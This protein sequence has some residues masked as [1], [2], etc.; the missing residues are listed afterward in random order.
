MK[1]LINIAIILTGAALASISCQR[2][3]I[4]GEDSVA[5]GYMKLDFTVN[6][7]VYTDVDTRAVDPD[8]GGVQN[9]TL[10][11]FDENGLFVS[12]SRA[13]LVQGAADEEVGVSLSGKFSV[14][15]PGNTHFVHL[16]GNQN[17]T[18]FEE[19]NYEDMS[20]VEVMT[21]LQASAGRMIYW[22]REEVGNLVSGYTVNL[23]R[24]QAKVTVSIAESATFI[25]DGWVVT[26]TN[27]FGTVAPFSRDH[28][29]FTA[30][31]VTDPFVT[32]PEDN[33]KITGYYD[34]RDVADE[35]FFE[36]ENAEEDPVEFI[37]RGRNDAGSNNLYYRIS[38]ID[39]DGNFLPL[40]RNHNYIVNIVGPL[41]YGSATF[42]EALDSPATNNVWVSISENIPQVYDGDY[43]LSVD[44]TYVVVGEEDFTD[45]NTI[46]LGYTIKA[47]AAGASVD[48]N[49]VQVRWLDGNNVAERGF[50]P[51]T[52]SL[53]AD[54]HGSVTVTLLPMEDLQ[55]REGT[56]LV[57]YGR[58]SRKI[59]VV[60]V[61]KQSFVPSWITTNIYGGSAGENVTMMFTI[62]ETCPA[63]LFPL[64]VLVSVNDLDVRN[65]SGMVLPI[66]RDGDPGYGED[67]GIGYKY[68]HT[69]TGHGIQ[70]LY[71]ETSLSNEVFT[72]IEVTL[73]AD[74]F[75]LLKKTA[76]IQPEIDRYILIHNLRTYSATVPADEVIY[77]YLVPQ[78][79]GAVVKFPTHLGE[80]IIWNSDHTVA[81]WDAVTPGENDEFLI[82]SK[83]LDQDMAAE[84]QDF[85]FYPVDENVWASGGRVYGFKRNNTPDAGQG[86]TYRMIT[87]ASVCDEVVRIASNPF[88]QPSVTGSGT[89]SGG[90]YR[91]A[92]FDLMPF[93]PFRF[94]ATL[95]NVG[96]EQVYLSYEPGQPVDLAFDVTSFASYTGLAQSRTIISGGEQVSVD[97]FGQTFRIYIDAPMLEIDDAR[98]TLPSNKFYEE[99]DGRFVYVVDA[100]RDSERAYFPASTAS[101]ADG[102]TQDYLG[103]TGI[104]VN[105]TGER[106]LLPFRNKGIVSEGKIVLSSEKDLVVY[107]DQSFDLRNSSIAGTAT[108][109]PD[110]TNQTAV[111]AGAFLPF[112]V[113]PT[114]NRIGAITVGADGRYDLRLRSEYI[115]DWDTDDVSI[116]YVD[117]DGNIYEKHYDSIKELFDA[118]DIKLTPVAGN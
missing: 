42:A 79:K 115:Y 86:A 44:Q 20:E 51:E 95:N 82:Y 12:T 47:L 103:N 25:E 110:E 67:N 101:V 71:L 15:V 5:D 27:A 61:K 74:N 6:V 92:V 32:I 75:E 28:G 100:D 24:N 49:K 94:S 78:K 19:G 114:F 46:T 77:Y 113:Y 9:I 22:A 70:R 35:F 84:S 29:G 17:L 53:D 85:T 26:N 81:D 58:L 109:G 112:E 73:E 57:K 56:L 7:P 63:E 1:R 45:P 76:T 34:V 50:T 23:L 65:E 118:P 106:K 4:F 40:M 41:S 38:L 43:M 11:C 69:V 37:I 60:T 39:K 54:G 102:S 2:E 107:A 14:S 21:S 108:F 83:Y 117:E 62:P 10:F 111:P 13:N 3:N 68:V 80:N 30:P 33:T 104:A 93:D 116:Q 64:S 96:T 59:K 66:I 8:G 16:V 97:P 90:Q 31:S 72:P 88:G 87:N 55:K 89:C 99:S 48:M 52:P 91:S 98:N 18:Y 36:T 105:Q